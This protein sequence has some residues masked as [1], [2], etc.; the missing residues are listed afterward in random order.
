MAQKATNQVEGLEHVPATEH[1]GGFPPF[2]TN[3][4]ASQVLWLALVFAA[5]YLLM[6]R[7]ALPRIGSIITARQHHIDRDLAEAKRLKDSSDEALAGYEKAM[8]D[9]RG[10]AQTLATKAREHHA[11][12]AEATRKALEAKLNAHVAEA[13]KGIAATKAAAMRNVHGVAADAAAAI[14]ERLIGIVPGAK[15]VEAAL[16]DAIKR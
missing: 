5:L 3:T 10:R 16:A 13:D 14:V 9:A 6:S 2:Q 11:A 7:I 12:E 1:G 15:E 4:F 8:A